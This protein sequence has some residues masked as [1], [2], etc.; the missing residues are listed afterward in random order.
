MP[1]T[2]A[3]IYLSSP[4]K[5]CKGPCQNFNC[6]FMASSHSSLLKKENEERKRRQ[7]FL[8]LDYFG[9]LVQS[10]EVWLE[11]TLLKGGVMQ[12]SHGEAQLPMC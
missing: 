12:L 8:A 4:P 7:V 1:R 2:R 3:A 10:W 9:P 11:L 6:I 5:D